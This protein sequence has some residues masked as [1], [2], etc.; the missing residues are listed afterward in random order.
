MQTCNQCGLPINN[1]PMG[2]I[3]PLCRCNWSIKNPTYPIIPNEL[4]QL[5]Q[6]IIDLQSEINELKCIIQDKLKKEE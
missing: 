2:T 5:K 3:L 1:V 6:Q 4:E